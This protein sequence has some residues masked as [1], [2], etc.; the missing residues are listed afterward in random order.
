MH[1]ISIP[2]TAL[3]LALMLLWSSAGA[4]VPSAEAQVRETMDAVIAVLK[5]N[6][7]S[8]DEKDTRLRALVDERFDFRAMAQRTLGKEW[9]PASTEEQTRF[10]ELFREQL[11]RTYLSAITT[12]TDERVDV[13]KETIKDNRYAQVDTSIIAKD[14]SIPVNYR[15]YLRGE[16]WFVYDVVIEG[17][18][19]VRNYRT[20]YQ[21]IV[22]KQGMGTLLAQME[23]K[24]Q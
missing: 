1:L 11:A 16:D 21:G 23:E 6:A 9:K 7:L 15:L 22:K 24:L 12:Y 3:T 10:I 13:T 17:A 14:K 19:L 20:S 5:D 8:A 2:A 4:D 18:S